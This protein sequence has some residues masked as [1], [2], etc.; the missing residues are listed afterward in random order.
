[1]ADQRVDTK[2]PTYRVFDVSSVMLTTVGFIGLWLS[3]LIRDF[4]RVSEREFMATAGGS[5]TVWLLSACFLVG[6]MVLF[7]ISL[8]LRRRAGVP[9]PGPTL[10]RWIA[11]PATAIL[12][13]VIVILA[14]LL[15]AGV[16][17]WLINH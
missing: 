13:V 6:L 3:K 17:T 11:W 1:M 4:Q 5:A 9:L 10:P 14:L 7:P 2:W 16:I 12:L 15:V 8:C